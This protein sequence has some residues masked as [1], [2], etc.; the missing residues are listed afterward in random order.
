SRQG[1]QPAGAPVR[2]YLVDKGYSLQTLYWLTGTAAFFLSPIADNLTTALL[3]G[4]VIIA[5]GAKDEEYVGLCCINIVVAANAGGAFSPFGDVTTLMVWQ[6]GKLHIPDFIKLFVPSLVNW[7]V[8]A[9]IMG[10]YLST[11]GEPVRAGLHETVRLHPAALHVILMFLLTVMLATGFHSFAH[12]PPVLGMVTGLGVLKVYGYVMTVLSGYNVHGTD[13]DRIPKHVQ[14]L[15]V[16]KR[17]AQAEWDTLL[18]FYGVI[19]SVGGLGLLGYLDK[20]AFF[21]YG[22]FGPPVANIALGILSAL[23]DNIPVM[24]AVLSTDPRM[25]DAQWLLVTLTAGCGGSILSIGS[26]AGVGLMGTAR[27]LYNFKV[28]LKWSWAV[29]LGYFSSVVVHLLLNGK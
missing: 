24:F 13:L 12:L 21:A 7:L 18:F 29:L 4:A 1:L 26:A 15:D 14:A 9:S 22:T 28:H 25:S 20:L 17:L 11:S 19:M 16:F 23:V 3:M 6:K 2:I 5:V 8:P 10:L 27:G